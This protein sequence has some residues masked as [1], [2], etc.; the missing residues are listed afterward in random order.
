M[1]GFVHC[2]IRSLNLSGRVSALTTHPRARKLQT[3]YIFL[4][5]AA[6]IVRNQEQPHGWPKPAN[7]DVFLKISGLCGLL[8]GFNDLQKMLSGFYVV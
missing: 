3:S 8:L 7:I 6:R 2:C 5:R 1:L 4:F